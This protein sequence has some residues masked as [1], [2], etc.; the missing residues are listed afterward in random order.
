[1]THQAIHGVHLTFLRPD[2]L[3]KAPIQPSKIMIAQSIG[4][5]IVVAPPNDGLGLVIAEG[6]E[7]A[8]SAH[9]ATGLGAWAAG[10]AGRMPRLANAVPTYIEAVTII[11]DND[12]A[13][14][15]GAHELASRLR[16]RGIDAILSILDARGAEA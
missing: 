4:L 3:G 2:G 13:G 9:A 6:I 7:D 12:Q 1:V 15:R 11:A 5:P 14:Q 8:L 10:S 16:A